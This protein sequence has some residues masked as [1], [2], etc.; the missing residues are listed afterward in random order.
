MTLAPL[1]L[2]TQALVNQQ[3]VTD[4]YGLAYRVQQRAFDDALRVELSGLAY[5]AG[6][7]SLA[8]LRIT[9]QVDDAL[10][11][12]AGGNRYFG[13]PDGILGALKPN[14]TWFVQLQYSM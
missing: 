14:N 1:I 9:Y 12:I 2:A 6:Q 13:A 7:G 4:L 11:L 3:P 5:S 10:S 8:R